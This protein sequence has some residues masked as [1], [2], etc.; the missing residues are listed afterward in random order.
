MQWSGAPPL[1]RPDGRQ[2]PLRR[3][4]AVATS[5]ESKTTSNAAQPRTEMPRCLACP[6]AAGA[7]QP[8]T[9]MPRSLSASH[10]SIPH[11]LSPLPC[12]PLPPI[13]RFSHRRPRS[14]LTCDSVFPPHPTHRHTSPAIHARCLP[15]CSVSL[16]VLVTLLPPQLLTLLSR[17]KISHSPSRSPA[18]LPSSART[19]SAAPCLP[20]STSSAV[21]ILTAEPGQTPSRSFR[22][23]PRRAHH[24]VVLS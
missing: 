12:P 8:R 7:S 2:R 13:P 14:S 18:Q 22:A 15:P 1:P 17:L 9:D 6:W 3:A 10:R 11:P 19:R 5:Y 20:R 21:Q 16:T 4:P 24:G 23:P